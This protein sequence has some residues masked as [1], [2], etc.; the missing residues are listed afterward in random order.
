MNVWWRYSSAKCDHFNGHF[1]CPPKKWPYMVQYLYFRILEF[2]LTIWD[3]WALRP[4]ALYYSWPRRSG[5]SGLDGGAAGNLRR[6][7]LSHW[8]HWRCRGATL[9]G[10]VRLV[11]AVRGCLDLHRVNTC[12]YTLYQQLWTIKSIAQIPLNFLE[13]VEGTSITGTLP[14]FGWYMKNNH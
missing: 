14:V 11:K 13:L 6:Q 4:W 1:K 2:P 10:H 9:D 8:S 5:G 7:E 3:L 12:Q